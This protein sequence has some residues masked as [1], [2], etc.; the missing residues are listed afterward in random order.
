MARSDKK[1]TWRDFFEKNEL[2]KIGNGEIEEEEDE[3]SSGEEAGGS[4]SDP[5]ENNMDAG[6]LMQI[7]ETAFEGEEPE[8]MQELQVAAA[9]AAVPAES[10][11][12]KKRA[13]P[14]AAVEEQKKAKTTS[15][16]NEDIANLPYNFI[17]K[18]PVTLVYPGTIK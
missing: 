7:L 4:D 18:P 2:D 6:E 12:E 3:E 14:A 16:L 9:A 15:L 8:L 5:S 17:V 11:E 1:P 13:P 10:K